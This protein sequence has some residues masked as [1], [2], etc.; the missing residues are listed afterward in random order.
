VCVVI[1][2]AFH[3]Q[4][5]GQSGRWCCQGERWKNLQRRCRCCGKG[6]FGNTLFGSVCILFLLSCPRWERFRNGP[7]IWRLKGYEVVWNIGIFY[8]W[9]LPLNVFGIIVG[10]FRLIR[11][12]LESALTFW[13]WECVKYFVH[14]NNHVIK[15]FLKTFI[16]LSIHALKFPIIL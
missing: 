8:L 4:K 1:S 15:V 11:I 12:R 6:R 7:G 14:R 3:S 10:L 5:S 9:W 2:W 16:F 13:L